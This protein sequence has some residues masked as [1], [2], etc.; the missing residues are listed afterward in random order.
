LNYQD[1]LKHKAQ[2]DINSGFDPVW[3]PD[4]LFDF[5]KYL[6]DWAVKKGRA[7]IFADCGLGKTVMQLVTAQNIVKKTN[8]PVLIITPL[9]VSAQTVREGEKFGIDC[10]QSRDGKFKKKIVVTNYE[11]LHFFDW[12]D[13]DGGE[14][15]CDESSAIKNF[16]GQRQRQVIRF[17]RKIPFRQL[18]TATA[19]PNDFDELG[20]SSEALG[21]MKYFDMLHMFFYNQSNTVN[22]RKHWIRTGGPPSTWRFKKHAEMPFW[23]WVCSWAKV[24][25]RPSDI[26]FGDNGFELPELTTE[27][28]VV[29]ASRPMP[30]RLFVEPAVTISEQRMERKITINERCEKVAQLVDHNEQAIVWCQYNPEGDLLEKMIPDAVQVAGSDHEKHKE[31]TFLRFANGD[32]RVLVTK[33]KIGAFGLNFQNCHH[34][35]FFPSHSFEQHYQGVRRCWRFGQKSPVKVDIVTTVGEFRVLRNLIRKSKQAD[36]MFN[37]LTKLSN[38]AQNISFVEQFK[39]RMEVPPWMTN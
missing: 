24:V 14:V 6:V 35:T 4:F 33:P 7:A 3:M 13:F 26:G 9:A 18:G 37:M 22:P 16:T 34:M 39:K 2:S 15:I 19:A 17:M 38:E 30:G 20:T 36:H 31:E 23:K 10:E 25:R 12:Q 8:K 1:F 21:E 29:E 28:H 11:K 27:E 5:Q 32:I